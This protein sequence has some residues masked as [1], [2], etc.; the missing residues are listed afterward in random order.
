MVQG[1]GFRFFVQR[2]AERLYLTGYV[3]NTQDGRVE[4][5]AIGAGEQLAAF[6]AALEQG[7]RSSRVTRVQEEAAELDAGYAGGFVILN[8]L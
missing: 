4:A 7:P 6:R 8:T 3:R 2:E 5:Y 1:V